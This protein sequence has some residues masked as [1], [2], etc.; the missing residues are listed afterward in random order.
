MD[1]KPLMELFET[2]HK[3]ATMT[4]Q[5]TPIQKTKLAF[6]ILQVKQ[7]ELIIEELKKLND[8]LMESDGSMK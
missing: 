3:I 8:R 6:M 7:N 5:N 2:H 1:L 4:T